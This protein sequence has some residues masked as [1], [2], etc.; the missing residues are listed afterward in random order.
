MSRQQKPN[1][2]QIETGIS[3][4]LIGPALSVNGANRE[5]A[6]DTEETTSPRLPCIGTP[7]E[8]ADDEAEW[9]RQFAASE[10]FLKELAEEAR[11]ERHRGN[12]L[13]L[14]TLLDG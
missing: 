2:Q 10:D 4:N 6:A 11:A 13:S 14:D 12:L 5:I 7:D 3:D 9:D 8:E 1:L